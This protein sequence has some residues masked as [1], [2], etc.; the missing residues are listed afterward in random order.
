MKFSKTSRQRFPAASSYDG[1]HA[2]KIIQDAVS[3]ERDDVANYCLPKTWPADREQRRLASDRGTLPGLT[4]RADDRPPPLRRGA[5]RQPARFLR[6]LNWAG[7]SV[8]R[9]RPYVQTGIRTPRRTIRSEH[10]AWTD[11]Q[12][13]LVQ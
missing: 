9:N 5:F 10:S 13:I 3:I 12:T 1:D 4:T 8:R 6:L 2:A 7:F 11:A